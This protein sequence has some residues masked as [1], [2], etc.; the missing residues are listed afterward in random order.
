MVLAQLLALKNE[1][2]SEAI[3]IL[4]NLWEAGN[5]QKNDKAACALL[6]KLL[7]VENQDDAYRMHQS[8]DP[9]KFLT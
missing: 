2:K 7:A 8:L 5:P 3:N 9:P 1:T 6:M 4:K